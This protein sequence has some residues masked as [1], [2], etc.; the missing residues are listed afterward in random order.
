M[1]IE[2][3]INAVLRN[4]RR[5]DD[6]RNTYAYLFK[7]EAVLVVRRARSGVSGRDGGRWRDVIIESAVLVPGDDEQALVPV[8]RFAD[9]FVDRFDQCL[10]VGDAIEWML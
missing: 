5:D 1:I 4:P 8:R 9:R 3:V 7:G 6:G 10:A 2:L